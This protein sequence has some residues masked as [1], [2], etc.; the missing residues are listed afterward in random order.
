MTQPGEV[1]SIAILRALDLGDMLCAVPAFRAVRRHYPLARITLCGLPRARTFVAHFPH[2]FDD[3]VE[4]PGYEGLPE[5]EVDAEAWRTFPAEMSARKF[6]LAIQMHGS[7]GI[8]NGLLPY[9][10][11]RAMAGYHPADEPPPPGDFV[12]W[13]DGKHEIE[14]WLA[15]TDALGMERVG[16]HLEFPVSPAG[17]LE[18]DELAARYTLRRDRYAVMHVGAKWESRRWPPA[19]FER[20]AQCLEREG[21]QVVLTGVAAERELAELVASGNS[22]RVNLAGATTLGGFA[23]VL[24][25]ARVVVTNDTGASH[26]AVA[27]EAPSVTVSCG[28]D[29]NRWAPLDKGQHPTFALKLACRPCM[30]EQCPYG[31]QCADVDPDLVARTAIRLSRRAEAV[32]GLALAGR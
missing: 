6:D 11:A 26:M 24:R 15:L 3:F 22:T 29:T 20:V 18:V 4:F 9:F 2:L 12:T 10:R 7:G 13:E 16:S 5:R 23:E 8:T 25:G 27:V 19:S 30:F 1:R 21:L 28:S 14:T 31:H 32:P 17:E